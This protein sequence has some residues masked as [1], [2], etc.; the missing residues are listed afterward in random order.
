[1]LGIL[2]GVTR[3]FLAV[4]R[5]YSWS[6]N[7]IAIAGTYDITFNQ[8]T[9]EY[10]FSGGAP[11]SIVKIIGSATAP[12]SMITT[13]AENYTATNVTLVDGNAQFEL[14]WF[15]GYFGRPFIP[16]RIGR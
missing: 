13:D 7:I 16:Q 6:P 12:V 10:T 2:L 8:N 4:R 3:L 1:M 11:I 14:E 5:H 15:N 9:G